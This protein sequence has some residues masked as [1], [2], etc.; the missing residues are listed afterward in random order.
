MSVPPA[1]GSGAHIHW[2]PWPY[3]TGYQEIKRLSQ[4]DLTTGTKG[5]HQ[6]PLFFLLGWL[7][8]SISHFQLLHHWTC[9]LFWDRPPSPINFLKGPGKFFPETHIFL[10]FDAPLSM[11]VS[12]ASFMDIF[13]PPEQTLKWRSWLEDIFQWKLE[14]TDFDSQLDGY[15]YRINTHLLNL[16]FKAFWKWFHF[17]SRYSLTYKVSSLAELFLQL[18]W[19]FQQAVTWRGHSFLPDCLIFP[20]L[21]PLILPWSLLWL[22]H[23][24]TKVKVSEDLK[25]QAKQITKQKS[26]AG[27]KRSKRKGPGVEVGLV[28]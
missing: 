10:H 19:A 28:L 17:N 18:L 3:N 25:K 7:W 21:Q 16:A 5:E 14:V 4:V 2:P 8:N 13:R 6:L 11:L 15:P 9:K 1:E 22:R 20:T 27:T 23:N 26:L 24:G 12:L